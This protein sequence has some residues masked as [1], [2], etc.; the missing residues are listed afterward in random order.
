MISKCEWHDYAGYLQWHKQV[1]AEIEQLIEK[2]YK[3]T[4]P[5]C[6]SRYSAAD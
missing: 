5:C 4:A 1:V 2:W 3:K 6:G